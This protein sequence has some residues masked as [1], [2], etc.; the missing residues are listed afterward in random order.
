MTFDY[1][2]KYRT[3]D[4]IDLPRL[5]NDDFFEPIRLLY[6]ARHYVSA[7]KLLL[8]FIDT[9]GYIEY[10][11]GDQ[12][13]FIAWLNKNVDL[14]RVDVSSIELWE[15]RNSLLHMSNLD[16][17]RVVSGDVKRLIP[18]L[19]A[20]PETVA[21]QLG[22]DK[23]YNLQHLILAVA[24]GCEPWLQ[25]YNDHREKITEF[26]KRYDLIASDSRMLE[27]ELPSSDG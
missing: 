22:S 11:D 9:A 10:G 23:F 16:S 24:R 5:I 27:I 1:L 26:T 19:G 12:N 14:T 25:S 18:Y 6:Q 4:A 17:R 8:V 21:K 7:T 3:D 13:P 20:L 2:I 15:H